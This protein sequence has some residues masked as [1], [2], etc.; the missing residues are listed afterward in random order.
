MPKGIACWT[1]WQIMT[2]GGTKTEAVDPFG[3]QDTVTRVTSCDDVAMSI[4]WYISAPAGLVTVTAA[5]RR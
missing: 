1:D 3:E 4:Y 2:R 5:V